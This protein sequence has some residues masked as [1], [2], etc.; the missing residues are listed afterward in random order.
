[1]NRSFVFVAAASGLLASA[2]ASVPMASHEADLA[3]KKFEVPPGRA[4]LYVF[5][6]EGFGGAV[7]MSVQL[8]G[9]VLG[10]T[11][12]KAYLYSPIPPGLHTVVSKSENDSQ[13]TIDAK[14]GANYFVW[15]EVKMGVWRA[16]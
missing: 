8:D 1:M 14:P 6:N 4:N 16:D 3:A 15:Q 5:R 11:A 12:A 2:C 13:L 7:R 9:A 10:D